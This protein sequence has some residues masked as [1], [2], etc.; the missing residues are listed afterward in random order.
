MINIFR[1]IAV[2][3]NN[4]FIFHRKKFK[5]SKNCKKI[6]ENYF[7]ID[8]IFD[9]ILLTNRLRYFSTTTFRYQ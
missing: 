8:H 7:F 9:R 6:D 2:F 3:F 4:F 5:E 1:Q